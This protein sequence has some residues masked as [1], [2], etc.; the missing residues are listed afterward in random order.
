M[1]MK[2]SKKLINA[3][4]KQLA[5]SFK[6][7][8]INSLFESDCQRH[9]HYSLSLPN[10]IFDYS[11]QLVDK[12]VM[13]A[14]LEFSEKQN[15]KEKIQKLVNGEVVNATE[16][17]PALHTELRNLSNPT[18]NC[19]A[20]LRVL[21]KMEL[22][23][24]QIH[25]NQWRGYSGKPITDVV[26]IGVGGSD[27]GPFM[28]AEALKEHASLPAKSIGVHFVSSMDGSQV[29]NLLEKLSNETTLFIICS[30]SFTT[31]DTFY[32]ADTAIAWLLE[33]G[34]DKQ[35]L[36]K[37]HV[38]GVSANSEKMS[39][40]GIPE[41]NQLAIWDWVGG[42]FSLWSAIG[43]S[44]AIKLGMDNFRELL[45]GAHM[46]DEHFQ[47]TSLEENVPVLM[48]LIGVWNATFLEINAHSVLP[49]DGRLKHLPNYLTQLEMES[50]GK[51]AT[52]DG[53]LVDY[54]TCPIL[55]G[56][57]GSN[58]QHAFYQLLHQ[59]TQKVSCD[60]IASIKRYH[61]DSLVA[62][63][64]TRDSLINQH[65]LS[66]ANCFAQSRVLAFGN[67]ATGGPPENNHK[68]YR[69]NQPS[70]TFLM[71]ELTPFNL[72]SLIALYE[73]KVFVMSVMWDLNPFDQWG[74]ELG[75]KISEETSYAI[76]HGS[77]NNQFDS[78]T[79]SLIAKVRKLKNG[80]ID[81][82]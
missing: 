63:H 60:F 21:A 72:G 3:N 47:H 67:L 25:A 45:A 30:K 15:L 52:V 75:K 36:M 4:L 56:D 18:D 65:E 76:Q 33:S 11:K 57:I 78:S 73:H 12:N 79:M 49:Y 5:F 44:I 1:I 31:V 14:L 7:R 64:K 23:V 69:G 53:S 35:L 46:V 28:V 62:D 10:M 27:L 59:G 71:D 50:N 61:Q 16:N 81:A 19:V 42:R 55:W 24:D 58:A 70:S 80:D 66:L 32:N 68:L 74:V 54:K 37:H 8:D 26:N 17:R 82:G 41:N 39:R 34:A 29:F 40:W 38:V 9:E 20:V 6:K 48:G 2:I 13:D 51:S 77:C 22:I 43:V